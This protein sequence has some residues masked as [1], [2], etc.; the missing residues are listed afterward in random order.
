MIFG[1]FLEI[2]LLDSFFR[3][4]MKCL[5]VY[6]IFDDVYGSQNVIKNVVKNMNEK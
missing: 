1:N 4:F 2:C 6:V 3:D 5:R